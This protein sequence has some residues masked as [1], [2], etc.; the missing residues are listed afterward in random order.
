MRCRWPISS[1]P[2]FCFADHMRLQH[3]Y[4]GCLHK[5]YG[6]V[7]HNSNNGN[8]VI[9]INNNSKIQVIFTSTAELLLIRITAM[10]KTQMDHTVPKTIYIIELAAA[11]P[12]PTLRYAFF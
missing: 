12:P 9:L 4:S 3:A 10:E 11:K 1:K 6:M 5:S 7:K 8:T 2:I